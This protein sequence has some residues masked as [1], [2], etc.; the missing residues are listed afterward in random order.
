MNFKDHFSRLAA[1]YASFRPRY[2][3]ALFDYLEECCPRRDCAWDCA[4]GS[5][6][7]TLALATRFAAV[8][9]TD[10]SAAQLAWTMNGAELNAYRCDYCHQWHVGKRFR[11]D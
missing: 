3:P 5:G 4:C 1:H 8:I 7:A 11:D 2:P 10:A 6:Q 9:A